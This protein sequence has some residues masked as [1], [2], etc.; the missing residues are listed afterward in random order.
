MSTH[1]PPSTP[2][3]P[4]EGQ[5][6]VDPRGALRPPQ[7]PPVRQQTPQGPPAGPPPMMPPPMFYPPPQKS[8]GAGRAVLLTLLGL[9][10]FVGLIVIGLFVLIGGLASA[11]GGDA[12]AVV[13]R[14]VDAGERDQT[15]A[16]I[17]VAG[18]IVD[19]TQQRFQRD[20][21]AAAAD[22][23]V[24][25]LVVT[26]S[27]P[28]GTVTDS[29]QMYHALLGFKS[30]RNVPIVVHMD[31]VAASGGYFIACA[32]DEIY[33]EETTI[34]GSIGVLI[35]F[36]QLSEFAEKTGIRLETIV[37]DGSP[38]KDFLDTFTETD[39][40]DMVAV[41]EL[42]NDQYDLFR[43][44]VQAGRGSQIAAAG[45]SI[46]EAASGAVFLGPRAKQLGLVDRIG[47]LSDA[48]A[49]AASLAGLADP[50]V[51]RYDRPPTLAETLGLA[52]E[53]PSF[54]AASLKSLAVELMHEATA[55]RSLYLY[56]G[57]R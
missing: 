23:N 8:G 38:K 29:N 32:A 26:V 40:E 19:E 21:N 9:A 50:N 2:P 16:I 53:S 34:T 54:D 28:G 49:G 27:S 47:F 22:P 14:T 43:S 31:D 39:E 33:A 10:F 4:G 13:R 11:G 12:N 55:P 46:D 6:P 30:E 24:R 3:P 7:G 18:L 42:L 5:G 41:R 44:V 48:V 57:P 20:L 52:V 35:Q 1:T 37:A 15:V 56:A 36:P 51:V 17:P 45:A 25:A